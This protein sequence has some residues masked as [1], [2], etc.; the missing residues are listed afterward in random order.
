MYLDPD[1]YRL[2]RASAAAPQVGELIDWTLAQGVANGEDHIRSLTD[3]ELLVEGRPG[4][5]AQIGRLAIRLLGECIGNGANRGTQFGLLGRDGAQV[6]VDPYSYEVLLRS[7]GVTPVSVIC[8][9]LEE[10]R[11]ELGAE[12]CLRTLSAGLPVLVR[13]GAVRLDR[14]RPS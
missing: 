7:D 3:A 13:S 2:W 1:L 14:G 5:E 10:A 4:V 6:N 9:E 8:G 11:P 12:V